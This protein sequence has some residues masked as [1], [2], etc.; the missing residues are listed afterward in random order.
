MACRNYKLRSF[1][2]L[3]KTASDEASLLNMDS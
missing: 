2:Q 3:S 1:V